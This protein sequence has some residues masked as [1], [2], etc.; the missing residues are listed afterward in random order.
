MRRVLLIAAALLVVAVGC[1]NRDNEVV[2]P[3]TILEVDTTE[4]AIDHEAQKVEIA[5]VCNEE[6]EVEEEV[7]W[8][9]VTNVREDEGEAKVVVLNVLANESE[10]ARSAEVVIVAGDVKHTV[11]ITQSG[12]VATSMEVT[13][14]HSNKQMSSPKWGGD[15]ISGTI[16]WGDGTSEEYAEGVAHEYSDSGSHTAIFTMSG[17]TSFEIEKIGDMESLM[18]AVE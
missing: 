9:A 10:E 13:I 15:A 18:I 6:F 12:M 14:A 4:I 3:P 5:V 8:L 7:F 2:A 1:K 16:N 17:A 11:T